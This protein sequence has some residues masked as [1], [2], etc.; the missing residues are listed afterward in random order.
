MAQKTQTLGIG[1]MICDKESEIEVPEE[2]GEALG[3]SVLNICKECSQKTPEELG[4]REWA[5]RWVRQKP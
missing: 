2:I 4:E 1:C 3:A 5:W